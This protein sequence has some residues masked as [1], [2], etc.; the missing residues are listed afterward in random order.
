MLLFKGL[1]SMIRKLGSIVQAMTLL[2]TTKKT[3][4]P[5]VT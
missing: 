2:M 1:E 3:A 5:K 4:K